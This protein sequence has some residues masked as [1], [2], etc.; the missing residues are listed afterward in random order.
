MF[1]YKKGWGLHLKGCP[2]VFLILKF[3]DEIKRNLKLGLNMYFWNKNQRKMKF[4]QNIY[5]MI[6][7]P[8]SF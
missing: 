6:C 8:I 3:D 7:D 1:I 4:N 5:K 2:K